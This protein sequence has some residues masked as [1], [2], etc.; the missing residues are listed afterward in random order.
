LTSTEKTT[1]EQLFE[2][3]LAAAG[4]SFE[5]EPK[6][7]QKGKVLDYRIEWEGRGHFFEVKDFE[8]PPLPTGGTFAVQMYGPI[9][10]R[11]LRCRKKFKEYKEFCCAAVFFNTGALAMLE[12]DHAMLGAMYG[13][14][15][16]RFP[17]DAE[18]G[19][20]DSREMEQ[21]FLGGGS[22][23]DP[24]GLPENTT[25][26]ALITL[27]MINPGYQKLVGLIRN[28]KMSLQECIAYAESDPDLDTKM[29]VPRVIVWHN[30]WARIPFPKTL[31]CGPY[32]AHFGIVRLED[33]SI[34]QT[35]TF[36]G[37]LLPPHIEY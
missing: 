6:Y 23:I 24:T 26:S 11:I 12:S 1:G 21:A 13:D 22:M 19:T 27:T 28:E 2:R 14:S 7:A 18:T 9:R 16:F 31:F 35:L 32:D 20:F 4:L 17:F 15:G 5:R 3:Y 25:I 36:R 30:A 10:E 33:G 37:D 34:A 8:S 29:T